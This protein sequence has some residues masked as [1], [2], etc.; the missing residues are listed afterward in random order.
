MLFHGTGIYQWDT[1]GVRKRGTDEFHVF[2]LQTARPGSTRTAEELACWGH[3]Y[4]TNLLDWTELPV[5]LPPMPKGQI[6]DLQSW[7]GSVVD[8]EGKYYFYYTARSSDTNGRQ[9][10]IFLATSDDLMTWEP[11]EGNPVISPDP[12]W[13]DTYENPGIYGV[14]D[15]RD[16]MVVKHDKKPGHFCVFV[17]RIPSEEFQPGAVLAGAYSE[18]MIHWEQTPPIYSDPKHRFTI[19][20][21]AD[22]FKL[23]DKWVLT[24]L[25]DSRYGNRDILGDYFSTSATFYAVSD[26]VEGPYV[27]PEDNTLL[28]SWNF[29][30]YS[31]RTL[32]WNGEKLALYV[33]GGQT[34]GNPHRPRQDVLG[35]PKKVIADGDQV[36]LA[37]WDGIREKVVDT[38]IAA[39]TLPPTTGLKDA[40]ENPGRW[41]AENGQI[42]GA[43][44]Y[45]WSRYAFGP[46]AENFIYTASVT[47]QSGVAAGLMFLQRSSN[48]GLC[49]FLDVDAQRIGVATIH[50]FYIVDLRPMKLEAGRTYEVRVMVIERHIDVFVDGI[51]MVQC[52]SHVGGKGP[53]GV[54]VDRAEAAFSNI[55]LEILGGY[56][57]YKTPQEG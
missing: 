49:A 55:Q 2:Y 33:M 45:G 35:I 24:W 28:R 36:H 20:E 5:T 40:Y 16:P 53:V 23:G 15:C 39:G 25:S 46:D 41:N 42:T 3:A 9:Q 30:G 57:E 47:L 11:Y 54:L 32:D 21:M 51:L 12:R 27:E 19:V 10:R 17:P 50:G 29:N 6:G 43:S 14:V 4:S 22:L 1:F 48:D 18:D 44:Q 13:Y 38:P 8:W 37:W 52:Q 26:N 7:T 31:L 56:A 34:L